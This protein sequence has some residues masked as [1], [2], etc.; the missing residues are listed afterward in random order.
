VCRKATAI[1]AMEA[2]GI[3]ASS[4]LLCSGC[5]A[6]HV[7]EQRARRV[8]PIGLPAVPPVPTSR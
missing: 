5:L 7:R 8:T 2:N 3:A 6:K 1:V 4:S